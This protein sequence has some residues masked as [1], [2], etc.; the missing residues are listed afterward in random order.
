MSAVLARVR[1]LTCTISGA[2]SP[3]SGAPLL[4]LL[5]PPM[6]ELLSGTVA[7]SLLQHALSVPAEGH[8]L[9]G[10]TD[11]G[12]GA[13]TLRLSWKTRSMVQ[14]FFMPKRQ[15]MLLTKYLR[16][17]GEHLTSPHHPRHTILLLWQTPSSLEYPGIAKGGTGFCWSPWSLRF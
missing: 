15:K 10:D 13:K 4:S 2:P 8:C 11:E 1:I 16:V 3:L 5:T 6:T 12:L 7:T 9:D 17:I 14:L